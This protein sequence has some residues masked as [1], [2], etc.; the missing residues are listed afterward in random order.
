MAGRKSHRRIDDANAIEPRSGSDLQ[1]NVAAGYIGLTSESAF[2][3]L[4]GLRRRLPEAPGWPPGR[5]PGLEGETA[6]RFLSSSGSDVHW[7][8]EPLRPS[9]TKLP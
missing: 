8:F 7:H 3:T 1:P 5:N 2:P 6:S 4:S 9:L